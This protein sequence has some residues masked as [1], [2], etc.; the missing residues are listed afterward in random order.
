MNSTPVERNVPSDGPTG[1]AD[2]QLAHAHEKI[3]Q[4]DEQ[5]TRLSEQL[6][7]MERDD[8]APASGRARPAITARAIISNA[9]ASD[10]VTARKAG[11]RGSRWPAAGSGHRCRGPGLAIVLWRRGPPFAAARFNAIIAAGKSAVAAQPTPSTVQL[12]S[13]EAAPPQVAPPPSPATPGANS[14]RRP[15]RP[16]EAATGDGRTAAIRSNA[17]AANDR[18]RSRESG[19]EHRTAQDEPATD[20]QRQFKS[21][22]RAQGQPGRDETCAREGF[23]ARRRPRRHRCRRRRASALRRP[24]RPSAAASES[25][26]A[27][28]IPA[29]DGSTTIGSR[30]RSS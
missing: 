26:A 1:R 3:V 16:Q 30:R 8:R 12:A 17:V 15:H 14:L 29:G 21:H 23:R 22:W 18:A 27:I 9:A 25:A 24:E 28:S 6:A 10:T 11:A 7:K 2:E 4:A 13:A 19:A 20:G 5:L